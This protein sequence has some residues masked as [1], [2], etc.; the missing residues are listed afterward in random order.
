MEFFAIAFSTFLGAAVALLAER[1]TR[2]RDARLREEAAINNLILDL[3]AK[4]AFLVNDDWV[5]ADGEPSRV[6]DSIF[7]ARTL[8]REARISLMP[9]SRAL[10]HLRSMARACNTFIEL[11]EREDDQGLKKALM[12][13]TEELTIEV[14]QLFALEPRRHF[15]DLPGSFALK[16]ST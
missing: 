1:L 12:R 10:P 16:A 11:S 13:L 8:I 3:A 9:R 6:V 5:W 4:R 14:R 2:R 15:G 7:H